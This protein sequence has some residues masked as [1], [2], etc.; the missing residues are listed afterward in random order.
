MFSLVAR[1]TNTYLDDLLT[2]FFKPASSV[3][4]PSSDVEEDDDAFTVKIDLP[5]LEK[6]DVTIKVEDSVLMIEG[7]KK[8]EESKKKFWQTERRKFESF[9]RSFTLGDI[10]DVDKLQ[11]T[12]TN[13]VLEII[14]PKKEEKKPKVLNIEIK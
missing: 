4:L 11:A 5:G 7:V 14:L 12:M 9:K 10:V 8:S 2:D 3:Y 13:G 1:P 6:S